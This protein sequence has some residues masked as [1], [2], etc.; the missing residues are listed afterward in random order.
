MQFLEIMQLA[1]LSI[2]WPVLLVMSV[3]IFYR[4]YR[5]Y[6]KLQATI[7][8]KLIIPSVVSLLFGLY[9]LGIVSTA[10]MLGYPNWL[11][12]VFP[13][14]L[15]FLVVVTVMMI[16]MKSWQDQAED[17]YNFYNDLEKLVKKRTTELEEAHQKLLQHEKEIQKL[18][19]QFVFIAAHELKTPV[20]AIKWSI[21]SALEDSQEELKP[22]LLESLEMVQD[23]NQRLL[24]LVEDLLNVARIEA[25]TFTIETSKFGLVPLVGTTIKSMKS[26]FKQGQI[27]VEFNPGEDI[28]V[29]ADVGR[30]KQILINLL[31]NATKYN[32]HPGRITV[33]IERLSDTA[34]V[35]IT[36]TGVGIKEEDMKTLFTKF[37]R[38]AS[39]ETS[40]VQGTGLG[41]Y[42]SKQMVEKMGGDIGATSTVGQGSTFYF[43]LPLADTES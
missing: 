27:E 32:T 19:D 14:F 40:E 30:V 16:T 37:G 26:V 36:D 34:T 13:I 18:K 11:L 28:E 4:G 35:S 29:E 3:V 31:S 6:S 21:E 20:T 2:G 10:Y 22:E 17:L 8:G 15:L 25:G 1:I 12:V 42:I 23:S 9:S 38:I 24:L 41:L 5:F 33:N 7:I 43:S 39:E